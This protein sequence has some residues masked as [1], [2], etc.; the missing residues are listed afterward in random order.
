M[1]NSQQIIKSELE[2]PLRFTLMDDLFI[3]EVPAS[4]SFNKRV[5][6]EDELK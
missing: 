5:I 2:F 3:A 4:I 1:T 6:S